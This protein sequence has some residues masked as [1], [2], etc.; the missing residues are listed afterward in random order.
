M[1]RL[2]FLLVQAPHPH[3]ELGHREPHARVLCYDN[4]ECSAWIGAPKRTLY[5]KRAA[6]GDACWLCFRAF[7]EKL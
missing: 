7:W 5:Q 1:P 6:R 3:P 4:A 2:F